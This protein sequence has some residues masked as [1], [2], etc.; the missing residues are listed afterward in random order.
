MPLPRS[1]VTLEDKQ[2]ITELLL[3]SGARI[4]EIN[5]VRKHISDFK[6]G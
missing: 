4:D 1:D 5:A 2:N 6:G 3:K